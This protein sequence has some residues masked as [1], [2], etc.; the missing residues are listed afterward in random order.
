M[1]PN[2]EDLP[3]FPQVAAVIG[4]VQARLELFKAVGW[5]K[6]ADK[7]QEAGTSLRDASLICSFAWDFTP[8]GLRFWADVYS[9]KDP[10]TKHDEFIE[11]FLPCE[12]PDPERIE[13]IAHNGNEGL[14]YETNKPR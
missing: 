9:G 11:H 3:C 14:H 7:N 1:K 8:Q 4:R 5:K 12:W 10:C 13:I 6:W 2:I